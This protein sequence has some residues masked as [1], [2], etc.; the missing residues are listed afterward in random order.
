[1]FP[2]KEPIT[3]PRIKRLDLDEVFGKG[4]VT[5]NENWITWEVFHQ[6]KRGDQ[7]IHVGIVHAPDE[8][9]AL[10]FAKE[11]FGRRLKCVNIWVVKS[12]HIHTFSTE[13]EDMFDNA[14]APEKLY[15]EAAGFKVMEKINRY[16]K[17]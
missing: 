10:L 17:I 2:I 15:R 16:K 5:E 8:E 9:L 1:M 13:D 14:V 3:D 12:A 4:R 7:H 6:K 11:Q